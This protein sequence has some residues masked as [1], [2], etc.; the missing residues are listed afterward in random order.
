MTQPQHNAKPDPSADPVQRIRRFYKAAAAEPHEGAWA[1]RLDGRT[2]R[3][4]GGRPLALPGEALAQVV[5]A[6]WEGQGEFIL[7]TAMPATRLAFTTLDR[8]ADA[9]DGL[10]DEVARYAG[11]DALCYFAEQPAALL[12]R[13]EAQWSPLLD[14]AEAELGLRFERAA[15]IVHR[16]QPPETLAR[17]R[18]LAAALDDF[19]LTA[20]AY[21]APLFGSAVLALAV[22]RGRLS[23]AE[24]F[25]LSR[26]DEAW[27]EELWGVDYEAAI[28]T[29]AL[30]AESE[31]LDRW[32]A[33]LR[34]A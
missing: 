5:A 25:A 7:F 16:L 27:Q 30:R 6:E 11:S 10:A 17:M 24:A 28:R 31:A 14:W 34:G 33:A 12:A 1:V 8:A 23:G 18:Q 2:A 19:A 32:F 29:A 4:P 26:L 9:R 21:A 15:G 22:Q 20:L 13:Q 3:T